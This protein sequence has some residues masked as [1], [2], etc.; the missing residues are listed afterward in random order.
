MTD[1]SLKCQCG[2]VQGKLSLVSPEAGNH[3]V[4]YCADCQAFANHLST[5]DGI[6][7]EW[8][9]TDI[10]QTAPWNVN[11]HAGIDKLR[12]IR[13]SSKGL[14]R[15]YTDCCNTPVGNTISAK[16]PFIGLIHSF[17]NAGGQ[18]GQLLGP[19][20]GYH[21]LQSARGEVTDNIQKKGMPVGTT[22]K[23]FWLLIKWKLMAGNKPNPFFD[24]SGKSISKP[25]IIDR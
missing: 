25:V 18:T 9:G 15:W 5:G 10:Y 4:C 19:V 14:Y 21:K 6:L 23:V 8:G 2:S 20:K 16:F 1:I 7:D 17:I 3:I 12:C 22:I 11:I 24:E 13:L